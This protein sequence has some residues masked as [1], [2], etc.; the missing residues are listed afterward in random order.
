M[1][2]IGLDLS[3]TNTGWAILEVGKK[4]RRERGTI[5]SQDHGDIPAK[6]DKFKNRRERIGYI[7]QQVCEKTCLS[8]RSKAIV[9][10]EEAVVVHRSNAIS[11]GE[12]AGV[13]KQMVY[14]ATKLDAIEI[15]NTSLKKFITGR[16]SGKKEDM[17]LALYKK[18]DIDFQNLSN[19]ASDAYGLT[20]LGKSLFDPM[21]K[22]ELKKFEEDVIAKLY[23]NKNTAVQL[24][25]AEKRVQKLLQRK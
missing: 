11:A 16:G 6:P 10:M 22:F 14:N 12:L 23:K 7:V 3:L 4:V 18:Y 24:K 2:I 19:D 8:I 15:P 17:K 13:M 5:V 1:W 20:R 25:D 21:E 9:L